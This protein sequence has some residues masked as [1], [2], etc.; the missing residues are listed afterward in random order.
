[1]D[2]KHRGARLFLIAGAVVV[3]LYGANLVYCQHSAL[4]L[5]DA[6]AIDSDMHANLMWA[7]GIEAQGWLNPH[8]YHPSTDWMQA[9]APYAQWVEW[10]GGR[11]NLSAVS[12]VCLPA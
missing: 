5:L 9:I 8:P 10:W 11:E 4:R 6:A 1:V 2:S 12:S 7:K 3:F